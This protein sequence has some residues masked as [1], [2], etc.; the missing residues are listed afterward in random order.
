M[1]H[2]VKGSGEINVN[3]RAPKGT[4]VKARG[5]GMFEKTNLNR[6]FAHERSQEHASPAETS[7]R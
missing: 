5:G 1:Q 2:T 4:D 6:S 7:P 3:V